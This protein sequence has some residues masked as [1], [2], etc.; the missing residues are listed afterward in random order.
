MSMTNDSTAAEAASE[1]KSS[2]AAIDAI[3]FYWRPGCGFCSALSR[4]L[5]RMQVPLRRHNIWDD[6]ADAAI[7]RG[8]ARGNETVPTVVIGKVGMVNPTPAEVVSALAAH[9]PHLMPE[10]VEAPASGLLGR[11]LRKLGGD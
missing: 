8:F 1:S 6:P 11:A 7:V 2:N 9:A 10:G 5:E 4:S 3:D